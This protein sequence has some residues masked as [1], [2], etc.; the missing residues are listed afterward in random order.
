MLLGYK[1]FIAGFRI[2]ENIA[3]AKKIIKDTFIVNKI[4]SKLSD[5]KVDKTGMFLLDKNGEFVKPSEVP[6][7]L[8]KKAMSE[9]KNVKLTPEEINSIERNQ[10]LQDVRELLKG[11]EGH[12]Q[13]FTYLYIREMVP[14][15][16]LKTILSGLVE[17]SDLLSKL[18]RPISNYIDPKIPNNAENLVDDIEEL[19]RWRK[20]KKFI[21]EFTSDLKRDY[22]V[23]P[24]F[25]KDKLVDVA[26]SFDELG[27]DEETGKIDHD[28]QRSIQK[29]FFDKIRR[30][31]TINELV[32]AAE[33]FLKAEASADSSKFY[34]AIDNCNKKYGSYGADLLFDENGLLIVEVKSYQAC[35]DLYSNTSWCIASS[36]YQW[37]SYV[38][39]DSKFTRQ[40]CVTN[41]N[42]PISDNES[43]IGITIEQDGSPVACHLKNDSNAI[44]TFKRTFEKFERDLGLKK[45]FIFEGMLPMSEKDIEVKKKRLVAN[46]EIVKSDINLET[47]KK[48]VIE[49][50]ADVN[51]RSG[52]ALDQAVV[53][54]DPD[55]PKYKD[56][57]NRVKFLLDYGASPNLKTESD[58]VVD[59]V[60]TFEIFKMLI[61][62]GASL[63]KKA[64]STLHSDYE[65][66]KFC[67]E[68][69]LDPNFKENMP[70]R[71]AIRSG[72]LD[73]VKLLEEY[74]VSEENRRSSNTKTAAENMKFDI[75]DYLINRGGN[76]AKNFDVVM[77]W[78]THSNKLT[79]DQKKT[80]LNKLQKDYVDTG[81][82][83]FGDID[84]K[85]GNELLNSSQIVKKFKS[86]ENY[87]LYLLDKKK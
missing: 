6:N 86:M 63:T 49:D 81:K 8:E 2:N 29:R 64:F 11:M 58:S 9:I 25:F 31:K 53:D 23:T 26:A 14:L 78:V 15:D 45:G 54:A 5:L 71:L 70:M 82:V 16:E 67:L 10:M 24:K 87:Y 12:A 44:S 39:G 42:L 80:V 61:E 3:G 7:E 46:R 33:I 84:Y 85:V 48:Y 79:I 77:F 21:Q 57:L 72:R 20:L 52:K 34:I 51:A 32:A 4:I 19:K 27:K 22:K 73:I 37:D 55:S 68:N 62:K 1:N 43:I 47:L 36:Q 13:L 74:N 50:G 69:G 65:A 83:T 17:Y 41:F 56:A 40:Y 76:N 28:K 18:R 75:L 30:Y 38:G 66:V 60:K 35:K 59:K